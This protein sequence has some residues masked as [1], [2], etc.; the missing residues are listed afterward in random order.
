MIKGEIFKLKKEFKSQY[1]PK[2]YNHHFIYWADEYDKLR[3]IMLTT[4]NNEYYGN[5][6]MKEEHFKT[7]FELGFGKSTKY[8]FSFIAPLY[9]LK[10]VEYEHLKKT[11]ELSDIG[12]FFIED[13]IGSLRY[14]D[15]LRYKN[16]EV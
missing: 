6:P 10:D 3:G 13:I 9:L 14:T 7:G 2:C 1:L 16:G 5:I 12:N 15:W 4:S 8:P 11:G